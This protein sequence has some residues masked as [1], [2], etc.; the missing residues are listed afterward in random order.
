[1]LRQ[2][3]QL[4]LVNVKFLG[5][6]G[7][8]SPDLG[9]LAGG[10]KTADNVVCT[11]GGTPL[12]KT[13][14]GLAWKA[15]YDARFPNQFQVVSPHTYDATMVLA[16]AMTRAGSAD[17]RVYAPA[18]FNTDFQGLMARIRFEADG[19][20]KDPPMTLYVYRAGKKTTLD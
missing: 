9:K 19:E 12:E 10:A 16:D 13:A 1:M 17:P 5:G 4:G 20:M 15:R 7:I 6:D 14:S 3:E 8:C 11:E 2:M 18:L